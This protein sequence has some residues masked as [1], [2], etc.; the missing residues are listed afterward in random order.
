MQCISTSRMHDDST[1]TDRLL[2]IVSMG[3][4]SDSKLRASPDHNFFLILGD[5]FY[6]VLGPLH[7]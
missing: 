2:P 7:S 1:T 6:S 3:S 4:A 5:S